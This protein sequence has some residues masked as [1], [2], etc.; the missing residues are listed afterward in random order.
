MKR[1]ASA[2]KRSSESGTSIVAR[3]PVRRTAAEF[4]VCVANPGHPASLE[5]HKI[6]R[7]L[8]DADAARDGD[9]RVVDESGEDYLFPAAW[10]A[11]VTLSGRVRSSLL[12][13]G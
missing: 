7:V 11:P 2:G 10:F 6:Y 13:V 4:V 1:T 3:R 12:R 5:I 9:L 8:A